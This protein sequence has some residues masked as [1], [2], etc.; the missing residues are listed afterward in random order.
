MRQTTKRM[1]GT[2]N[3]KTPKQG[4]KFETQLEKEEIKKN[5]I[6]KMYKKKIDEHREK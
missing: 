1:K 4:N 5:K 2:T 6:C 3:Q